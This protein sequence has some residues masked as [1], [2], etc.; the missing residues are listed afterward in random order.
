MIRRVRVETNGPVELRASTWLSAAE[1]HVV[2]L[3][4]KGLATALG[5]GPELAGTVEAAELLSRR[6]GELGSAIV[7]AHLGD[8]GAYRPHVHEDGDD[9]RSCEAC[10]RRLQAVC[11]AELAGEG[12]GHGDGDA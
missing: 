6:F 3:A 9:I 2:S 7:Q 11:L 4:C 1:C 10:A 12:R 5:N 8:G